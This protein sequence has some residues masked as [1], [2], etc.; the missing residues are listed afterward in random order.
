[1]RNNLD[2]ETSPYLLQ[3]RD[4]PVHW[5]PWG[6]EALATAAAEDKPILLSVGYAACHWCHVMAHESFENP[7]IA[8]L[9]NELFVNIKVDRE[10][11]PDLDAV[12]QQALALLGEHGG[13]PL[14]MFLTPGAEPFWG[15]TYFP[16]TDRYGR[17]GFPQILRRVAEVY[18]S[19]PEAIAKNKDALVEALGRSSQVEGEAVPLHLGI[20]D[21]VAAGLQ[22]NVDM[23]FGGIGGAPKFPQTTAF[24]LLWRA[25]LRSGN[26]VYRNAV[27]TTLEQMCQGGI[28]DHLGGGFARYATDER[29]LVPH[30]EKMLYDNAQLLDLLTL[31]WQHTKKPLYRHRVYET[32]A[33]TLAEMVGEGGGFAS[34]LDA[35]SEGEEGKFYV[36]S[37]AEIDTALGAQAAAFKAAYDV[38][39]GGNWEG[40]TILNRSDAPALQDS[41]NEARLTE[42][43]QRL[44]DVRAGRIRPG[45]DDKVLADWNGLMI[46]ALATAGTVFD[47]PDWVAAA[48]RAFA[49]ISTLMAD[50]DRLRHSYRAGQAK[51]AGMLDDYANMCRAALA[52]DEAT[53]EPAYRAQAE[54]WLEVVDGH[55]ADLT[56]GGYY[57]SADDAQD[58]I[59]RQRHCA[60]QAVPAG[61]AVLAAVSARLWHLTAEPRHRQ[62]AERIFEAFSGQL[63]QNYFS[64]TTYLNAFELF[65]RPV[66]IVL[67][68]TAGDA[69][70]EALRRAA[71]AASL[72]TRVL[73]LVSPKLALPAA[74]PAYG[75]GQVDGRATAYVCIGETCSLPVTDAD[76]LAALLPTM[77][78][79]D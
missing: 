70:L 34:S 24:E 6:P 65:I 61:N 56:E 67:V 54:A 48:G 38:R 5:Q 10:E 32:V 21:E 79:A 71:Y 66:Q 7:T 53:A 64:L 33:W 50:G 20:L 76:G 62:R 75:K 13:W 35:D 47:E 74:H 45:W 25:Y 39:P 37:E 17:P 63:R 28:Y 16:D 41:D 69:T 12:Y 40:M 29:W 42:A 49:A 8:A 73:S 44:L 60:D 68:G 23:T 2:R 55:F 15:G 36:W 11:R 78:G 18:R 3:H 19:Q 51:H 4:N 43:R 58:L 72:P 22:K 59:T 27:E 30:F 9:M 77:P 46:A 1:M 57:V 31:V 26:E 52:L 14:T